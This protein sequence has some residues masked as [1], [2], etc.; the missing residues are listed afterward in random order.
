VWGK[1]FGELYLNGE[2]IKKAVAVL[3][4]PTS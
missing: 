4:E 2:G 3:E 1:K